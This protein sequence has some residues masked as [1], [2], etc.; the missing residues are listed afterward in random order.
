[1]AEGRTPGSFKGDAVLANRLV[2]VVFR[3]GAAGAEV[4]A[5][6][7]ERAGLKAVLV[8]LANGSKMEISSVKATANEHKQALAF[9]DLI[10]RE[11]VVV[12]GDAM[13]CQRDLS[14][15]RRGW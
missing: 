10:P 8:P 1:M 7:G 15:T 5:G 6:S 14:R 2:S 4:Y 3:K 11:G 12:T 13:F 9:L